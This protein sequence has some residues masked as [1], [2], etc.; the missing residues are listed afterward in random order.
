[1]PSADVSQGEEGA[2][3]YPLWLALFDRVASVVCVHVCSYV[4]V[5]LSRTDISC[6]F[7][8]A[9]GGGKGV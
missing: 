3:A 9:S 7:S 4:C 8:T 5:S 6:Y 2:G 1:M